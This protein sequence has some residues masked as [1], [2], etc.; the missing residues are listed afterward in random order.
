M[1]AEKNVRPDPH[2]RHDTPVVGQFP[3]RADPDWMPWELATLCADCE[4]VHNQPGGSCPR[5]T[6]QHGILLSRLLAAKRAV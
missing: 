3:F 2:V 1:S 6:S 5:C 4:T